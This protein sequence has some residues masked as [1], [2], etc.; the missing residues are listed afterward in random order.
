MNGATQEVTQEYQD[1]DT[2]CDGQSK[3]SCSSDEEI[4]CFHTQSR[5]QQKHACIWQLR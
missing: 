5:T 2:E 3:S 4:A 1:S